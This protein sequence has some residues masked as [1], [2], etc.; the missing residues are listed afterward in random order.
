MK[1]VV[2]QAD[3]EVARVAAEANK[4]KWSRFVYCGALTASTTLLVTYGVSP[5]LTVPLGAFAAWWTFVCTRALW[6][7]V[8][9]RIE[10]WRLHQAPQGPT[11]EEIYEQSA[12]AAR[13]RPH[14]TPP[15]ARKRKLWEWLSN[16]KLDR[17]INV[18]T[19]IGVL[20]FPALLWFPLIFW[21]F[22]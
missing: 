9:F 3:A 10:L 20:S 7:L 22:K 12:Q 8:S 4:M 6:T 15:A 19:V 21:L 1:N 11:L 18:G 5:W 2:A 14:Q 16:P 17:W 13:E